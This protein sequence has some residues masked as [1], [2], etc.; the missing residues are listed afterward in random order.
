MELFKKIL[1]YTTVLTPNRRLS[2]TLL[3]KYDAYQRELNRTAWPTL[4]IL[5]FTTWL[6]QLWTSFA[7]QEIEITTI[8]LTP[9]QEHVIWEKILQDSPESE[10]L[11]QVSATA[12]LAKSA[13]S[14]M[15]QWQVPLSHP[16]LT[17]TDDGK[18]FQQWAFQFESL[19]QKQQ[20]ID[21]A[22]LADTLIENLQ[23][24][25]IPTPP[26][27]ILIGFTELSPQQQALLTLCEQLGSKVEIA[28]VHASQSSSAFR[29]S[30]TD[31]EDE[32][33]SMARW[34][35]ALIEHKSTTTIGCVIPHLET[36]RDTVSRIFAEIFS[37]PDSFTLHTTALPFNI[38]AGKP[39]TQYS[40]IHIAL[41][42]LN[43][44]HET[45]PLDVFSQL[46]YSPFLG[47]AEQERIK[48][49]NFDNRLRH[50]NVTSI[51]LAKL[52]N[53]Q[54]KINLISSCPALA[55]RL[56]AFM[57]KL[58]ELKK[59]LSTHQ[60]PT[61]FM[62][63]LTLLGWP[64]ERSLNSH[65]YQI[66]QQWLALLSEYRTFDTILP[67]QSYQNALFYLHR[68][69]AK[70]IYQPSSPETSVQVLGILEAAELPFDYLW[71]MGMNDTT[72]PPVPRPNPL[73]PQR[74]QKLLRM[75]H[76]TAEK[77]LIYCSHLLEQFKQS[78]NYII[79]S[80]SLK[81]QDCLLRASSLI[82]DLPEIKITDLTISQFISPAERLFHSRKIESIQ[83]EI[84]PPVSIDTFL[85][86]GTAIFKQQATCPFKA[87]AEL[88]LYAKHLEA[89]LLGLRPEERGTIIHKALEIIWKELNDSD[90][91]NS[92]DNQALDRL[93]HQAATL[94]IEY[95]IKK[96]ISSLRYL[97]LEIQRLKT[98]LRK[99]LALEKT[100]P[101][102][103]RTRNEIYFQQYQY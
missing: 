65:E 10:R 14:M 94:A 64:G 12:E 5:P 58:S 53:P 26:H 8:A 72:F 69:A 51:S 11:L 31:E 60:W 1:P 35:K 98:L 23:K 71:V 87:F 96:E 7:T 42:L 78:A 67:D 76:A 27:L 90:T 44:T 55:K 101:H 2:A 77:E 57:L 18:S 73:L 61:V 66:V 6:Q 34:A 84:A 15:K 40:I 30:L 75:P 37:P 48:R 47:E 88:R 36:I 19:C 79:F 63:L 100:R 93:I 89:P 103:T 95:V 49:A 21:S 25:L 92:L 22:S 46:L 62:D 39:L 38:S 54:E 4:T 81:N 32:I 102:C 99:W 85:A 50:A 13:W 68:L 9:Q 80:H 83:D 86:G 52:L 45:I 24:K 56:H 74:L 33:R 17:L 41:E 28:H 91:L 97:A 43:L 29:I 16:L 70:M 82:M 59:P 3:K 20:W